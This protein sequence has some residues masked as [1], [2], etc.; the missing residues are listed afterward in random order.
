METFEDSGVRFRYPSS[1]QFEREETGSGWTVFLQSSGTAFATITLDMEMPST[2]VVA[3]AALSAL[4]DEYPDL[5]ADEC[6][7]TLA[8]QPAIGHDIRFFSLDLTNTCWTRSFYTSQGTVLVLC[9]S[10][11]LD[12]AAHEPVLK[13]ICSSMDTS[14]E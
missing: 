7:E 3:E 4:R 10:S 2:N 5:E 12:L 6:I 14:D 1:W 8:G 9:Q 11:D 13:A